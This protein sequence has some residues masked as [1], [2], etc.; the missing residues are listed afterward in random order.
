MTTL[1]ADYESVATARS[2]FKTVLDRSERGHTVTVRRG[3]VLS[4]VTSAER[5]RAYFAKTCSPR[6]KVFHEDGRW[7][8]LLEGRPFVS[9][10]ATV[11]DAIDDLLVSLRE[12]AE[13]WEDRLQGAPNH[14]HNWAL[15]QLITLSSDDELRHWIERGDEP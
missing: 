14:E 3:G 10:G 15:V 1:V 11:D 5:L 6:T 7:V 9:E 13:D 2:D 4:A 8:A 12:Y